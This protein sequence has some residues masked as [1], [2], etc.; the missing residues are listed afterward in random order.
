MFFERLSYKLDLLHKSAQRTRVPSGQD[1]SEG[2]KETTTLSLTL[3]DRW[4]MFSAFCD[5]CKRSTKQ[6]VLFPTF[7]DFVVN[8][9]RGARGVFP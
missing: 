2:D 7:H 1:V 8:L 9:K 3:R 4:T 6:H 5:L